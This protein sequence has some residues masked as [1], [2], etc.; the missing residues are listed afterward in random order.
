M[1][2]ETKNRIWAVLKVILGKNHFEKLRAYHNLRYWVNLK[3]PKTFNEK[4][5]KIKLKD[6]P[7][8][9]ELSD[10]I[11]VREYVEKKIGNQHLTTIYQTTEDPD[12]IEWESLP[13]SFVIK[14][15]KSGGSQGVIIVNNK[16]TA[17]EAPY[18]IKQC[19]E[20]FREKFGSWTNE[21]WYTRIKPR[22][23]IEELLKDESGAI[24]T[25]YKFHCFSGKCHF[26][27]VDI[28]RFTN[29]KRSFYSPDWQLQ[30]F[31]YNYPP[32]SILGKP[33]NLKEMVKIAEALAQG[34]DFVRVDLYS[35]KNRI[36][37]GEM[38]FCPESGWCNFSPRIWD[39]KLGDL[40]P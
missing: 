17:L 29:H 20:A 31:T 39:K 1:D 9:T 22:L 6:N 27:Q 18:L 5:I 13:N 10:K 33:E 37:F 2:R 34:F 11:N 36:V 23:L 15:T 25:D 14:S 4:I 40:L 35:L 8:F 26:V 30:P 38:T 19:R 12:Y 16:E 24:P 32:A 28:D 3:N 21:D 7:I